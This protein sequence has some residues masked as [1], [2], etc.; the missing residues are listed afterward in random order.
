MA[1]MTLKQSHSLISLILHKILLQVKEDLSGSS[2][3]VNT[4]QRV[5]SLNQ[6]PQARPHSYIDDTEAHRISTTSKV[7]GIAASACQLTII[8]EDGAGVSSQ[9]IAPVDNHETIRVY[10]YQFCSQT[11]ISLLLDQLL[12]QLLYLT[13]KLEIHRQKM[14][15]KL[16]EFLTTLTLKALF[17]TSIT[18]LYSN[19]VIYTIYT[20]ARCVI[21]IYT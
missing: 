10:V 12:L 8:E 16:V 1:N 5:D 2:T 17:H 13:V 18:I 11:H 7:D 20:A 21:Y 14:R 6:Q 3:A 9:L 19:V 4:R 15:I